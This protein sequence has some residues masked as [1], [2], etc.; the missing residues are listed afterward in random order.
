MKK[1][2]LVAIVFAG[3]RDT[4]ATDSAG[5]ARASCATIGVDFARSV[6]PKQSAMRDA[7]WPREL[8]P[9]LQKKLQQVCAKDHW[10]VAALACMPDGATCPNAQAKLHKRDAL[11]IVTDL[12]M[13]KAATPQASP[14]GAIG[15]PLP[16][17]GP[18]PD[19]PTPVAA[20]T[21][22]IFL[23]EEPDRGARVASTYAL[24][25][26][27]SLTWTNHAH[28]AD[29]KASLACSAAAPAADRLWSWRVGKA[30]DLVVAEA[31]R[32]K[33]VYATYIYVTANGAPVERVELDMFGQ[34][35]AK[36]MFAAGRYT[37][38]QPS[39]RNALP[40]CG[41]MA[42]TLD[43]GH[44]ETHSCLQWS[45]EPMR[46]LT[47]VA[48]TR[49]VRDA[50]GFVLDELRLDID[51]KPIS[52]NDGV[53]HLVYELDATGAVAVERYKDGDDKPMASDGA[54]Y[55]LRTERDARGSEIR[56]TCL[57]PDDKPIAR[58]SGTSVELYRTD[59]NGCRTELR[60]YTPD[61]TTAA[62]DHD[63]VHGISYVNDDRCQVTQRTCLDAKE[64]PVAC[65]VSRP[66]RQVDRYDDRGNVIASKHHGPTGVP[67]G[68]GVYQVFEL[69][70][71]FDEFGNRIEQRCYNPGGAA[72][73][74]GATGYAGE[75]VTWDEAGRAVEFRYLDTAGKPG[76]NLGSS[77]RRLRYDNYDHPFETRLL[78]AK[79]E[80]FAMRGQSI[81]RDLY[82][83]AHRHFAVLL[84]DKTSEPA[85]YNGCYVG[86]TCPAGGATPWHAVR[87]VR[88][89]D[90]SVETNQFFDAR[91]QLMT[92]TDCRTAQCFD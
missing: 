48:T 45:G 9:E 91:G 35:E 7:A 23:T 76:T 83:A 69:R 89:S 55:G 49:Y 51:G 2:V 1:L 87:I 18:H 60:R 46:D 71:R 13:A 27:T 39:G 53:P 24:P 64:V 43:K 47:R 29:Q 67:G 33:Q 37:G 75:V 6:L 82:D 59:G 19:Y 3:C 57:G 90:G 70:N 44:L 66:A 20:G 5:A 38:R 26:R 65:G 41:A 63:R 36:L 80:L 62:V 72:V 68:D 16:E 79:N 61:G 85:L 40:A 11:S 25:A 81:R 12:V 8:A 58:V 92:T 21:D 4:P 73:D 52:K 54:C 30:K 78:D 77:A 15:S 28:C 50:N 22:K 17:V 42:Y 14:K 31:I 10:T 86:A 74:C 56:R 88:R 84:L 32:D 34:V